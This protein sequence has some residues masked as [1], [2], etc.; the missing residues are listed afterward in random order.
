[1]SGVRPRIGPAPASEAPRHIPPCLLRQRVGHEI[2]PVGA[3]RMAA[4]Q[5]RQ[6]HPAAGPQAEALD[7]L[8]SIVR[9][10][11]QVPAIETNKRRERV[12]IDFD[13]AP[14]GEA[15]SAAAEVGDGRQFILPRSSRRSCRR[16]WPRSGRWRRPRRRRSRASRR[17]ALCSRAPARVLRYRPICRHAAACRF[18]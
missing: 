6:S 4:Q 3:P 5:S 14:A 15:R 13:Q 12:A 7:R 17:G 16:A 10:G 11:R 9:A 1:M 8:V 2:E 18:P